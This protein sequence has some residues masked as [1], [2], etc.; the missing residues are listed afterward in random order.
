MRLEQRRYIAPW[1]SQQLVSGFL[2]TRHL[3]RTRVLKMP[4]EAQPRDV[5][6]RLTMA[7]Q[8]VRD[9][10]KA[11][12]QA[13]VELFPKLFSWKP[14][15]YDPDDHSDP[16]ADLLNRS[17]VYR[18]FALWSGR[19]ATK[20]HRAAAA[21]IEL[22]STACER[23]V[24]LRM[25]QN[26]IKDSAKETLEIKIKASEWADDWTILDQELR[27][28]KTGSTVVFKGCRD[29]DTI[30]SLEGATLTWFEEA[31]PVTQTVIDVLLPTIMRQATSRVLWTWNPMPDPQPVDALFRGDT[32]AERAL[33]RYMPVEGNRWLFVGDMIGDMRRSWLAESDPK[34]P[35]YLHIYCGAYFDSH[36]AVVLDP[37]NMTVGRFDFTKVLNQAA[38]IDRAGMDFSHGSGSGQHAAIGLSIIPADQLPGYDPDDPTCKTVIYI[39]RE[40]VRSVCPVDRLWEMA[41]AVGADGGSIYCDSANPLLTEA[42]GANGRVR[43]ELA[44]KGQNSINQGLAMLASVYLVFSPDCPTSYAQCKAL[45]WKTDKHGKVV[46]PLEAVG[47]DHCPDA[48]RYALSGL[49]L[50]IGRHGGGVV[51][52]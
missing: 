3:A 25:V 20:S 52:V 21:V 10:V 33:V 29:P 37:A 19:G 48:I 18:H 17:G 22:A 35:K 1:S 15:E 32:P 12:E 49:S 6:V 23:V 34:K 46:M 41:V 26:S 30:K 50:A 13:D 47:V 39:H 51:Y 28:N 24:C 9:R 43:A 42:V 14:P 31:G 8:A 27:N 5:A 4:P 40:D 36:D 7:P 11:A 16:L 44:V 2:I 38:I 45:R